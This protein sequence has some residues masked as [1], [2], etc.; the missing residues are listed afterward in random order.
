MIDDS[1]WPPYRE[2]Y[3]RSVGD[4]V[5]I[6]IDQFLEINGKKTQVIRYSEVLD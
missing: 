5:T 4:R 3:W 1:L 2:I 6:R